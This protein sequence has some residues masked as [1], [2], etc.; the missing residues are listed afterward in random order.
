MHSE[1]GGLG[2]FVTRDEL[3]LYFTRMLLELKVVFRNF[4][5]LRPKKIIGLSHV[6]RAHPENRARLLPKSNF[7]FF[8]FFIF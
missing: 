5:L 8:I 3:G 6:P 2:L 1:F 4:F 7:Y